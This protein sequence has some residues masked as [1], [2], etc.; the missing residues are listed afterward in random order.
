MSERERLSSQA[1]VEREVSGVKT[2]GPGGSG[3]V[4]QGEVQ[5]L[6]GPSADGPHLAHPRAW[7]GR[8]EEE[9]RCALVGI[10]WALTGEAAE[11]DLDLAIEVR[12]AMEG[13]EGPEGG[14]DRDRAWRAAAELVVMC[15]KRVEEQEQGRVERLPW[16]Q[17]WRV[18]EEPLVVEAR[19]LFDATG[20]G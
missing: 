1:S 7:E 2:D 8:S 5:G 10:A 12:D 6:G 17:P 14:P 20:P 3:G 9:R 19:R 15:A 18:E 11:L 16:Y 13:G 4:K